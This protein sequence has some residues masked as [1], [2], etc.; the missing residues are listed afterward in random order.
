MVRMKV[1]RGLCIVHV[2]SVYVMCSLTPSVDTSSVGR[3]RFC[4][5][6]ARECSGL[7][8]YV[9]LRERRQWDSD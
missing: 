4:V 9:W 6:Q 5:S 8:P 1:S 7:V 3:P 2:V